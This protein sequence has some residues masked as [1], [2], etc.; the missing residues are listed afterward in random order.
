M[1][2]NTTR[3]ST[4]AIETW[5]DLAGD[6]GYD[7]SY[8]TASAR[9]AWDVIL[10]RNAEREFAPR[11]QKALA[12][13]PLKGMSDELRLGLARGLREAGR[14]SEARALLT[15]ESSLSE[16]RKEREARS[17]SLDVAFEE[18]SGIVAPKIERGVPARSSQVTRH[19]PGCAERKSASSD[20]M[21]S[22]LLKS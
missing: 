20:R 5:L 22:A 9:R 19:G 6:T 2:A 4:G 14:T 1:A 18:T 3:D 8:R 11:L 13:L 10:A 17:T 21:R 12:D 7:A 16:S 15:P